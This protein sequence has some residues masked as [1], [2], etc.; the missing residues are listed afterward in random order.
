MPALHNKTNAD[1]IAEF[2]AG[3]TYDALPEDVLNAAR[4]CLVDWFGVALGAAPE[5]AVA[6]I[7]RVVNGWSTSGR[8]PILLDGEG[9][10]AAAGLV[11]GTMARSEASCRERV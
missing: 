6:A 1:A 9:S 2:V 8:A 5:P 4:F 7:K 11:N 10:P 3:T